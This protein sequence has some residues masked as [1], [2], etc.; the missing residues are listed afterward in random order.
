MRWRD[1]FF[2][3]Y[4]HNY[5]FICIALLS[6]CGCSKK[7]ADAPPPPPWEETEDK[8]PRP[9][10]LA[11]TGEAPLWVEFD[12]ENLTP[13]SSPEAATLKPFV[14]WPLA[15]HA[16]GIVH[17]GNELAIAVN[18][19]GFWLVKEEAGGLLGLYFLAETEFTPLYTMLKAFIFRG[20]PAFLLYRDD[21]FV[22]HDIPPPSSRVFTIKDDIYGL[23]AVGIPAFFDMDGWDIEDF[24]S[25]DDGVWYFKAVQKGGEAENI[26]YM[27]TGNLSAEG[28]E[29]TFGTYMQ[30]AMKAA[31]SREDGAEPSELP[32]WLPPLPQNFVYT[33]YSRFGGAGLAAW[34]ERENWNT[35][36]A[37]LLLL[38]I[39]LE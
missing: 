33:A 18:R 38:Q 26:R 30:A 39:D 36:A 9:T 27:R 17:W 29:I 15:E 34:E 1:S 37:G 8:K 23:E 20:K 6:I 32:S 31:G 12:G 24:F 21:F 13:I 25:L 11:R 5:F 2:V 4:Y 28:E 10:L 16:A 19:R 35:G 3:L 14:P 7:A 22:E